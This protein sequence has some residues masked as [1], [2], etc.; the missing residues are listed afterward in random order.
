MATFPIF[1]S[2]NLV[3]SLLNHIDDTDEPYGYWEP[4]HYLV[5]G[6]GMQ[7][8]EYAP[9]NA[10]RS[11]SFLLPFY[12]FLSVIKPIVTHK[13]VQFYLVR[14]LL[15]L[16][17][18]FAQ[19]RFISTLSAHRTL[20]PPMVSKITTVFILGSP[21]VLLS[22]TSLLPSALCSSL[23]LLGVCSWIDGG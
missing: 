12:I 6:H 5:H 4:L 8:W 21:G 17:T 14:L 22:G 16:F 3:A 2:V 1:F 13:I 11:Y 10:I 19:S 18:S 15:A 23:L 7:T 20:F 9:Q